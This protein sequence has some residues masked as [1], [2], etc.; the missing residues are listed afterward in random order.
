MPADDPQAPIPQD[1]AHVVEDDATCAEAATFLGVSERE[2]RRKAKEGTLP[3]YKV[4]GKFGRQWRFKWSDLRAYAEGQASGEARTS[5][6]A[7]LPSGPEVD[8]FLAHLD[9]HSEA[10]RELAESL[11]AVG[12]L[13]EV[14]QANT[15]AVKELHRE[16]AAER[17]RREQ[18]WWARFR[19]RKRA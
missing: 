7:V 15:E 16:L 4:G 11:G 19:G 12:E 14:V 13:R 1:I 3:A 8:A 10:M 2:V 9:G 6:L 18:S 17:A 5:E